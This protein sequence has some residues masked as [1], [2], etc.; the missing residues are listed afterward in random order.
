[1][2]AVKTKRAIPAAYKSMESEINSLRLYDM[3]KKNIDAPDLA[4]TVRR[5]PR[6]S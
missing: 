5:V 4:I 3:G 6:A 1:M 2:I